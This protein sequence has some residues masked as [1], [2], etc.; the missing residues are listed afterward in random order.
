MLDA[1]IPEVA[2][3]DSLVLLRRIGIPAQ[4]LQVDEAAVFSRCG[5]AR[6]TRDARRWSLWQGNRAGCSEPAE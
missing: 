2:E 4:D 1:E 5:E 6:H 3:S